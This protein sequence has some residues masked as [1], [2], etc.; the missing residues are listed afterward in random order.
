MNQGIFDLSMPAKLSRDDFLVS[1][2]NRPAFELI[3]HWPD[4]PALALVL[5][6]PPGS[7]KTHLAHLWCER[8]G[9]TLLAADQVAGIEPR[10]LAGAVAIDDADRAPE[11][12]LLHL[13]NACRER[14]GYILLTM[15]T[16][17][18]ALSVALAD[19]GSRLRS[20]PVIGIAPPDDTLLGGV[21]V[22]H[23][24]DRQLRVAPGLIA[25]LVPRMERSFAAASALVTQLDQRALTAN[26]PVTIKLA[27]EVLA[28]LAAY[29][30]PPS[31]LTVT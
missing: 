31:D 5:H 8:S 27:R 16:P 18:A 4:W 10:G 21:L 12:P 24:A 9:G 6:G 19:L 28:D 11:V 17:P 26:G 7:G 2:S 22:K 29:S 25:Y 20:L 13:Y 30:L 23:F 3:E 14:G 15:A 1:D